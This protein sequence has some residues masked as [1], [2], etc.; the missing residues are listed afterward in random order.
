MEILTQKYRRDPN[1]MVHSAYV[2]VAPGGGAV[3]RLTTVN[4]DADRMETSQEYSPGIPR[5]AGGRIATIILGGMVTT[6]DEVEYII[7]GM[8]EKPFVP[9]RSNNEISRMCQLV[10]ERRN[11]RIKYLRK[12][13]SEAPKPRP[14]GPAFY[15]P[16]GVKM[17]QTPIP[18][19]RIAVKE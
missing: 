19:F 2:G 3:T 12:N 4:R 10:A 14:Q 1:T 17:R 7:E 15:L 16:V 5:G 8:K 13:P 9:L 6:L 18:G 11:D